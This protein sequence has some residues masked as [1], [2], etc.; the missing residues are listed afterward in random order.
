M[1][2]IL[3]TLA[4]SFFLGAQPSLSQ[5]HD[6][7]V[8]VDVTV[9]PMD[10]EQSLVHRDVLV[11][12]GTVRSVDQHKPRRVW[13][14]GSIVVPG[15]GKYLLPGY[16]DM[17]IHTHFG[18]EQQLKL[19]IVNGVTTVLNLNGS[20]ESLAW[21]AKIASGEMLGPTLYTSGPILDGD[22]PTDPSHMV[23]KNRSEAE[24]EVGKQARQGYDFIKPYSALSLDAYEGI[25]S[26]AKRNHIRLVG[27]VSW[28][29]GVPR[30]IDSGQDAI[31]HVEELYRF[32]VNRHLKLPPDTQPDPQKIPALAKQ[33][34]QHNVWVITT[35]SA[36]TN[37][38]KQAINL[39]EVIYSP[40]VKFIP[41]TYLEECETDDPYAKRGT[42]WVLEN[43]IMVPFLFKIVDGLRLAG[44]NLMTGTDATIPIQIPG[45]SL[46]N[47]LEALVQSGF[48]PYEAL[49]TTTRNPQLFLGRFQGAGTV[50]PG[51]VADL[52]L[53]DANPL[54]DITNTRRIAGV[55]VRGRWFDRD[56]LEK[57]KQDLVTHFAVE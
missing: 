37:I 47:E 33:L 4:I 15:A 34:R 28:N 43:K 39:H 11:Q 50:T 30:T 46:H 24:R 36:N 42:D 55:V 49:V 2:T 31:A 56:Q 7:V 22:P 40:E 3:I 9:L 52:V 18:D 29:V 27:H 41:K 51:K 17:H 23:V 8:F 5:T 10:Q 12:G 44:V 26:A 6:I 53:L 54:E 45:F 48:T 57:I 20:P 13:P 16:S 35:L 19:Y 32:F 25:V 14:L 38:L 1:R 21:K